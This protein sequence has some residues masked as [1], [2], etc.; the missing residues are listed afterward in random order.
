MVLVDIIPCI[1]QTPNIR[2][3]MYLRAS[4]IIE[5][6]VSFCIVALIVS[7][8]WD[9]LSPHISLRSSDVVLECLFL[10]RNVRGILISFMVS[11]CSSVKDTCCVVFY[12]EIISATILY[13]IYYQL[14]VCPYFLSI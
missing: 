10:D 9:I 13:Q 7:A 14:P 4:G 8:S 2:S 3:Y 12:F 1:L 6:L 11:T 5:D